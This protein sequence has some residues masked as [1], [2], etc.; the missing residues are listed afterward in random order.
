MEW[1]HIKEYDVEHVTADVE[2]TM[3]IATPDKY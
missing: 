3:E 2:H 1:C